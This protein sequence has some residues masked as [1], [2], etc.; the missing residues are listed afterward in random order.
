MWKL[1]TASVTL[2]QQNWQPD[3]RQS[4]N[5]YPQGHINLYFEIQNFSVIITYF[6]LFPQ[7]YASVDVNQSESVIG[8]EIQG[9][10]GIM[11]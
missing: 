2:S 4:C 8:S 6:F 7:K 3:F 10:F 9:H 11:G 5:T 1:I